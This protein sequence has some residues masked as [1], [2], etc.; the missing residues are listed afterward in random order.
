MR[1]FG[2]RCVHGRAAVYQTPD[3]QLL[4]C[5]DIQSL[6]D[7]AN[8]YEVVRQMRALP[9]DGALVLRV[10]IVTA[11]PLLPLAPTMMPLEEIVRRLIGILL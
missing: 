9:F 10:A 3:E 4:G 2:G 7:L 1:G 11:L 5:G 8:S 6:A